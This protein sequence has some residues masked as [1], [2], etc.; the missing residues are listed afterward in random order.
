MHPIADEEFLYLGL[1]TFPSV[2]G[3]TCLRQKSPHTWVLIVRLLVA[4]NV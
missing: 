1:E 3:C 4:S 2:C